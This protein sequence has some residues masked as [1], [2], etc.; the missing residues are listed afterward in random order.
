[1]ELELFS[2]MEGD[3]VRERVSGDFGIIMEKIID[4]DWPTGVLYRRIE[5]RKIRYALAQNLEKLG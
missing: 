5:D 1:M 2:F 3:L 4:C